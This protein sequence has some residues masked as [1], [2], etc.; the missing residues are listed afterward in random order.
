M[1]AWKKDYISQDSSLGSMCKFLEASLNGE[2]CFVFPS[3]LPIGYSKDMIIRD[4][5]MGWMSYPE[6]LCDHGTDLATLH[7]YLW[8]LRINKEK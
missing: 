4:W 7:T 2:A 3:F 8:T 1:V 5:T 6:V